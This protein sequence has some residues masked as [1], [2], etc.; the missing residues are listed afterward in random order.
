MDSLMRAIQ[1]KR[2]FFESRQMHPSKEKSIHY[3]LQSL[4]FGKNVLSMDGWAFIDTTQNNK[5]DSIFITLTN[6]EKSYWVQTRP[7]QRP[8][9]AAAFGRTYLGDAG[10]NFIA[11]TDSLKPGRY[12]LGMAIKDAQ[13]QMVYNPT[14]SRSE[15]EPEYFIKK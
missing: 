9:L 1:I 13:G 10:F 2:E 5:G 15:S 14:L 7:V 8:D 3:W 6:G 11:F 4:N 12:Q